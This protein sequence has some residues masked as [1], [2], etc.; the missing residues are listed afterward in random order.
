M[1]GFLEKYFLDPI[2]YGTGYNVV[3]TAVYALLL[4]LLVLATIRL[5]KRIDLKLDR[6]FYAYFILFVYMGSSLRVLRDY[7]IITS[8]LF[9]T[10]GIYVIVYLVL[11]ASILLGLAFEK[12][13]KKPYHYPPFIIALLVDLYS[14]AKLLELG[15]DFLPLLQASI[16]AGFITVGVAMLLKKLGYTFLED[17]LNLGILSVHLFDASATFMGI[18]FYGLTAQHV[19]P[20]AIIAATHP[21]AMFL[22]KLGVVLPVLYYLGEVKDV[23][24]RNVLRAIV[25]TL[26]LAPG[27]RD[28]MMIM[29]MAVR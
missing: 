28:T 3:N 5:F 20:R 8:N 27:L 14:S 4:G 18:S 11:I 2:R 29:V 6:R 15:V 26:G 10:P 13:F 7:E 22:L 25:L 17:R 19:L 12:A 23:L 24:T 16:I 1:Q 21:A 9:K